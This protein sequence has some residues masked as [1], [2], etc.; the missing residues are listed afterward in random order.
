VRVDD[1]TSLRAVVLAGMAAVLAVAFPRAVSADEGDAAAEARRWAISA[2]AST[3][4][5]FVLPAGL[6]LGAT[7]ELLRRLGPGPVFLAART[8]WTAAS[9]AN[10][11]WII[12]HHQFVAAVGAGLAA[13]VGAGRLWA[14]AGGGAAALYEMLSRHQR[15]RVEAA[16]VP[17]G[18]ESS[19]TLGPYGFAEVGVAV[20]MRGG[21]SGFLAAGPALTHTRVDGGALWRLGGF[22]RVGVACAF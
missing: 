14:Q 17:G 10:V 19:F 3:A 5:P 20:D 15:D 18:T 13:R 9:A 6:S 16:G 21:V 22:A 8:G 1:W 4:T 12:D 7:A 11:A 2:S